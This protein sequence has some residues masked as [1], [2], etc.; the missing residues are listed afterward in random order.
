MRVKHSVW[1]SIGNL[2]AIS[3]LIVGISSYFLFNKMLIGPIFVGMGLGVVFYL[4]FVDVKFSSI[5]PDVI[6]GMVDNFVMVFATTLGGTLA[7]VGGAIIGGVTGNT[8]TD[9]LGGFFEG[10]VEEYLRK[11][12]INNHRTALSSMLG[13]IIGCLFGAGIGLTIIWLVSFVSF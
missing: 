12:K 11:K 8:I 13:K 1:Y 3:I 2:I 4:R 7:G 5:Y 9:G 10:V 6:F